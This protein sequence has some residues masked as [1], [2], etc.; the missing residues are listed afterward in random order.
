V[1]LTAGFGFSG[2]H[3]R[4]A[5]FLSELQRVGVCKVAKFSGWQRR[6]RWQAFVLIR[7]IQRSD[8][9]TAARQFGG[10]L[11]TA[12]AASAAFLTTGGDSQRSQFRSRGG[13]LCVAVRFASRQFLQAITASLRAVATTA[14]LWF[15]RR[16]IR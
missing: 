12:R 14:T 1:R 6:P 4:G 9:F 15:L 8:G 7:V 16:L 5:D 10:G 3:L 13:R 11:P 2:N